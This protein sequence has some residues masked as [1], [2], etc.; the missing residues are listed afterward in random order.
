MDRYAREPF[1]S[2]L[3]RLPLDN[4]VP[5]VAPPESPGL[6]AGLDVVLLIRFYHDFFWQDVDRDAVN[7]A[8]FEALRPGGVYGVVDH[9]AEAGSGARDVETLHRVDR[10][11][12][13]EEI[14]AAGFVLDD[15]SDVLRQEEDDRSWN[16]FVDDGARRDE[17]D[18]FVLRFVKP[19]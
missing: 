17:T 19:R 13:V 14:T 9:H 15:E 10:E 6:P 11:L 4:V 7:R 1:R 8:V 16:I 5:V 3:E 2:R 18:R 12:V